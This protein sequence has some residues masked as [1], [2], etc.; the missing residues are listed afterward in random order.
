MRRNWTPL[1]MPSEVVDQI[2]RLARRAK[3][4][5]DLRFTNVN[6][7]DLDILYASLPHNNEFEHD[8]L[9]N[10]ELAGLNDGKS[11]DSN[12]DSNYTM[13]A[14]KIRIKP[15]SNLKE[16][17]LRWRT[18]MKR[19]K[20]QE[21][22]KSMKQLKSQEWMKQTKQLKSQE[23]T[24]LFKTTAQTLQEWLK[25]TQMTM[26]EHISLPLTDTKATRSE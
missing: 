7:E 17:N 19:L 23:W 9:I 4:N 12:E 14:A 21:W 5:K 3:A 1:P 8:E 15:T 11:D 16:W 10:T 13:K 2:H 18:Q 24:N 22:T 6:N 20:F 25:R 26:R